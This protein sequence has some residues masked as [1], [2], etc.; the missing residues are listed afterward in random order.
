MSDMHDI[1]LLCSVVYEL[2]PVCILFI[3]NLWQN[4]ELVPKMEINYVTSTLSSADIFFIA[5]SPF[6]WR[7]QYTDLHSRTSSLSWE[8]VIVCGTATLC[9]TV[10][11]HN[12]KW[13]K[14]HLKCYIY[15]SLLFTPNLLS[16]K[17]HSLGYVL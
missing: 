7:K 13:N 2:R 6:W 14:P 8:P 9:S 5:F 4:K 1:K 3:T 10:I 12:A 16:S 11:K 17:I 15:N